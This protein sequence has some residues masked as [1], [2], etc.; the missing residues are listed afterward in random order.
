MRRVAL[1]VLALSLGACSVAPT[2]TDAGVDAAP[3][4]LMPR[5]ITEPTPVLGPDGTVAAGWARG[6]L[7]QYDRDAVPAE[8]ADAIREWEYYAVFAPTLAA[9]VT[10]SDVGIVSI[11]T[12]SVQDYAT[13]LV[14][15]EAMLGGDVELVLP[16]TPFES[17]R[18]DPAGG[19]FEHVYD[20]GTRTVTCGIGA[21]DVWEQARADLVIDDDPLGESIAVV[22][23]FPELGFFFYENKRVGLPAHGSLRVGDTTWELPEGTTFAVIDW[24]RG[25]WPADVQWEWA[26]ASGTSGGH[27]IGINLGSVHGDDSRGTA[28]GVV[29]DGVLHKL[30][31]VAW[32]FDAAD[33][34]APWRFTDDDGRIDVTMTPDFDESSSL[35]LGPYSMTTVKMHGSFEGSVVLD[36][37]STLA[38]EA[39][40][41]AAER[42]HIAW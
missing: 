16:S 7:M 13:G 19:F 31:R 12:V 9:S 14:H 3:P 30:G 17:T 20:A 15:S 4:A 26:A 29:V 34:S 40:R 39:V 10:V 42:V 33:P 28:D 41:G 22:T 38:I 24:G 11:A 36:D 37:G 5:E 32:S 8:H 18:W 23:R 27:R 21:A 35:R 2:T 25:V 6:P 1:I